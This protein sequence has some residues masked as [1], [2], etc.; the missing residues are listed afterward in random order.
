MPARQ[1]TIAD[2]VRLT[3]A[4]VGWTRETLAHHADLSWSAIAQVESGRRTK[5]RPDTLAA[6]ADALGVTIDY[7]VKGGGAPRVMLRHRALVYGSDEEF[8]DTLAPFVE[9][10]VERSE[11]VIVSTTSGRAARI[12]RRL[13]AAAERVEF[14]GSA[15]VYTRPDAALRHFRSFVEDRLAEGASWIRVVGEPVLAGRSA[16]ERRLWFRADSLANLTLA[17]YPVTLFCC[18]DERSSSEATIR[19]ACATHPETVRNGKTAPSAEYA[20]PRDFVLGS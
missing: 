20:D 4:R 11:P 13:G 17:S 6:L 10:G 14:R 3:R 8:V 18:Y 12:R 1:E 15:G 16:A 19:S 7:L 9:E 2:R 5:L